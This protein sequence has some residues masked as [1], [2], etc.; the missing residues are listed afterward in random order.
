MHVNPSF[1]HQTDSNNVDLKLQKNFVLSGRLHRLLC[2]P[3]STG[4]KSISKMDRLYLLTSSYYGQAHGVAP[5][6]QRPG[7]ES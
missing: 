2:L 3:P 1:L 6:E 5:L 4:S 7:T